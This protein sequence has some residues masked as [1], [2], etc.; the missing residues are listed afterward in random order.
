MG[1]L[2]HGCGMKRAYFSQRQAYYSKKEVPRKKDTRGTDMRGSEKRVI[3]VRDTGSRIFEEAYFIVRRGIGENG[4]PPSADE[5]VREAQ[6]IVQENGRLYPASARRRKIRG[7]L[8]TFLAGAASAGAVIG[9]CA[10]FFS[11]M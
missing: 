5:M 3:F 6:R 1:R 11:L 7:G 4:A 8:L 10:A 2:L 9:G